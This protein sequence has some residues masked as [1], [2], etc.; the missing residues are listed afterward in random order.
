MTLSPE[1]NDKKKNRM[2]PHCCET[3]LH[4]SVLPNFKKTGICDENTLNKRYSVPIVLTSSEES[5]WAWEQDY[6]H[7]KL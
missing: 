4:F 1:F 6:E 5:C 2:V 7:K 3:C